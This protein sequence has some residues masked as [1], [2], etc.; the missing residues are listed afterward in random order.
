MKGLLLELH[1]LRTRTAL[2]VGDV[3]VVGL[4]AVV[5][6]G[7]DVGA[8]QS[9]SLQGHPAAQFSLFFLLFNFKIA[10]KIPHRGSWAA[11]FWIWPNN[12]LRID[13]YFHICK[14]ISRASN[15]YRQYIYSS[16]HFL[17]RPIL[18]FI[19]PII[20]NQPM[21]LPGNRK[22]GCRSRRNPPN[23]W[24]HMDNLKWVVRIIPYES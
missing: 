11:W 18:K 8:R 16:L 6:S 4:V 7:A 12:H 13:R 3:V 17:L 14:H 22:Q 24:F 19:Y 9:K 5:T 10:W 15:C 1:V 20:L 23:N 2:P 21:G